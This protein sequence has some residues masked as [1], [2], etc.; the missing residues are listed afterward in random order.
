MGD[1]GQVVVAVLV[2]AGKPLRPFHVLDLGDDADLGQLG[3]NDFA[4]LARIG[5]G[6]QDQAQLQRCGDAGFLQQGL[7][8]VR[9]VRVD[10]GGVDI[11]K[12]A[13]HV[14]A[15]DWHAQTFVGAVD[16]CLAVHGSG[17]R[18][19]HAHIVQ[20]FLLV[21][22]R[23]NRLGARAVQLHLELRVVLEL[24]IALGV[25]AREGVDVA[26]QQCGDLRRRIADELE[27]DLAELDRARI[28]VA[29]PLQQRQ[30]CAVAPVFQLVWTGADRFGFVVVG[31]LGLNHDRRGLSQQEQEVGVH[32]LVEDHD[33]VLV[34]HHGRH[35]GEGALVLVRAALAGGTV[36]RVLHRGGV[37][38]L[39][40]L[41]LD[42]MAQVEGVGAQVGRDFP[43][44]GQHGRDAA[45]GIDLDQGF[46]D[47]VLH[48]LGNRRSR[49][50]R[51]VQAASG[52][53]RHADVDRVL[54]A[55]GQRRKSGQGGGRYGGQGEVTAFHT[56]VSSI[57]RAD[58]SK[59]F[60]Q[61]A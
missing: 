19:A 38:R 58:V 2:H 42:A 34:G 53:Q 15:T 48:H 46:E 49:R 30:R 50:R 12:G 59:D 7:G 31:R 40:V 27:G 13:R 1:D 47:V 14:M 5:H 61:K 16:H 60:R 45:V 25:D 9:V 52:L 35:V 44:F 57:K 21:V 10:A 29:V 39:T 11:A 22:D 33:G 36:E 56:Q 17:N 24:G 37:E 4:A 3:G 20:R 51:R 23:Q 43:A 8:L 32:F 54:L 55:V 28:A 18:T 6:R 41:E 26:G